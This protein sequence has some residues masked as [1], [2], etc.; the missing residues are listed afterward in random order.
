MLKLIPKTISAV[1]A[2]GLVAGVITILPGASDEV[3][4][5]VPLSAGK[6]DRLDIRAVGP[7]CAEQAWPYYEVKCL[8]DVRQPMAQAKAVRIVTTDRVAAR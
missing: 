8:K 4:A 1:I 7:N 5:S 6:G 3:A 2:A